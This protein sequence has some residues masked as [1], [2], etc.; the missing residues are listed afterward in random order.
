MA[1]TVPGSE[2][3]CWRRDTIVWRQTVYVEQPGQ[4]M[5]CLDG[6]MSS[7]LIV[8]AGLRLVGQLVCDCIEKP[9]YNGGLG[10]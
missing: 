3:A 9:F 5:C 2:E 1:H 10:F 8:M 7:I 6:V 4:I